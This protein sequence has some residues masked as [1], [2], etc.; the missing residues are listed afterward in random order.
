MVEEAKTLYVKHMHLINEQHPWNNLCFAL[1]TPVGD[2]GINL[3]TYFLSYLTWGGG[4]G[5][6]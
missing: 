1:F 6:G 3:L 2:L 4:G 5:G